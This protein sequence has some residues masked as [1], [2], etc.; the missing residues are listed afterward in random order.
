MGK[1]MLI[2]SRAGIWASQKQRGL[3]S[4][5]SAAWGALSTPRSHRHSHGAT[6]TALGRRL[7]V[8]QHPTSTNS[9]QLLLPWSPCWQGCPQWQRAL[10]GA[11][12]TGCTRGPGQT[13]RSPWQLGALGAWQYPMLTIHPWCCWRRVITLHNTISPIPSRI[14]LF[15]C[16]NLIS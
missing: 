13:Q 2:I 11:P 10:T 16:F 5:I 4:S 15:F 3:C 8:R 7:C 12:G 1:A 6:S 14:Y 9:N